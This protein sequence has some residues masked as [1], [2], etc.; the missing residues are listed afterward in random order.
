MGVYTKLTSGFM[1]TPSPL[2]PSLD[3]R[4]KSASYALL[5][6][7]TSLKN[8]KPEQKISHLWIPLL[9]ETDLVKERKWVKESFSWWPYT[10]WEMRKMGNRRQLILAEIMKVQI[11]INWLPC[12]VFIWMRH[13]VKIRTMFDDSLCFQTY[14]TPRK[15]QHIWKK[16]WVNRTR[17]LLLL[18]MWF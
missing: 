13:Q 15:T 7:L 9:K 11:S 3:S 5:T 12:S 18:T 6:I 4:V 8:L 17:G 1:D 16:P 2:S 10:F 14:L